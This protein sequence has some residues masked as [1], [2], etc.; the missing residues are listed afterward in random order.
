MRDFDALLGEWDPAPPRRSPATD[1]LDRLGHQI[2]PNNWIVRSLNG[3]GPNGGWAGCLLGHIQM[4]YGGPIAA[5]GI[6]GL[7]RLMK[8]DRNLADAIE[9]LAIVAYREI[10]DNAWHP[11]LSVLKEDDSWRP[12][13]WCGIIA[14]YNDTAQSVNMI[15]DLIDDAIRYLYDQ[16]LRPHHE[17]YQRHVADRLLKEK[18][19]LTTELTVPPLV[20]GPVS[21]S[22]EYPPIP[23]AEEDSMAKVIPLPDWDPNVEFAE[24]LS[25]EPIA[26]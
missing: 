4:L 2:T 14:R 16:D 12:D 1:I 7:E 20:I 10:R 6:L 24:L 23:S 25:K 19:R 17:M 15:Y 8:W 13:C 21:E 18:A 11:V 3:E 5:E 26:A 9:A 22:G